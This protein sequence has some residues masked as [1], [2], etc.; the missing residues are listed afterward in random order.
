MPSPRVS[1]RRRARSGIDEQVVIDHLGLVGH[2][3]T[4]LAARYPR[5]V[6]RD[7]L[8]NAGALGL[9]DAARRYDPDCGVPFARYAMIRIRGAIIDS[10]RSRDWATRGLRRGMRETRQAEERLR[11][12]N[13]RE[14][15]T[16]EIATALG[17]DVERVRELRAAASA[18][19]LL[20]LDQR[21]GSE[22][23]QDTTLGETIEERDPAVCPQASLEHRE[24]TGTVRA[25]IQHLLPVQREVIE[26][27]YFHG[28]YLR[29]IADSLGVTE[30]RV[31]QIRAEAIAAM[32]AYFGVHFDGVP[33]VA[34]HA[35]GRR[36]R[37]AFVT[38]LTEL[39]TWR[40]R[41]DAADEPVGPLAGAVSA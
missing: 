7:E 16:A 39:T 35:P 15:T 36:A 12:A 14:P 40:T 17:V 21:I 34:E 18:A 28:E 37:A 6:D 13:G 38:A 31:S 23:G 33:A 9:V 30:A 32:R 29:T 5:H 3:V 27:Y 4:A 19:T 1:A 11:A 22:D 26:R 41:L 20:H 24:L 8:W 10:T 25:A 2:A